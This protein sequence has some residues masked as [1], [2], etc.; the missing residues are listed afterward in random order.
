MS[1]ALAQKPGEE[2]QWESTERCE[3]EVSR[4]SHEEAREA[5]ARTQ[6]D[7]DVEEMIAGVQAYPSQSRNR[8]QH[9]TVT[10]FRREHLHR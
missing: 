1:G 3:A 4:G 10:Q 7:R 5:G 6:G 8:K 2:T 9:L